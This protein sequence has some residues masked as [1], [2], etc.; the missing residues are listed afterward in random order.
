LN[1]PSC[2]ENAR[3]SAWLKKDISGGFR[4]HKATRNTNRV[5]LKA[6]PNGE[7]KSFL[8]TRANPSEKP[9]KII[10]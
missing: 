2:Q 10:P 1:N 7:G 5:R 3:L 9:L 6:M 4:K 8:K